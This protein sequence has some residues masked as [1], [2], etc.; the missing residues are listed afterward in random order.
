MA[1]LWLELCIQWKTWGFSDGA[2]SGSVGNGRG[3]HLQERNGR[4][5]PTAVSSGQH[6]SLMPTPFLDSV[7]PSGGAKRLWQKPLWQ[8]ASKADQVETLCLQLQA[9]VVGVPMDFDAALGF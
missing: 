6:S 2:Q 8:K 3:Q 5:A 9:P 1:S 4:R 7:C